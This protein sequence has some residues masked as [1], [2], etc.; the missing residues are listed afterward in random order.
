[1]SR[2]RLLPRLACF[3]LFLSAAALYADLPAITDED[4][5]PVESSWKG[6]MTQRG[7]HPDWGEIPSELDS[8]FTVTKRDGEDFEAELNESTQTLNITFVCKG[9]VL[10]KP[11]G[12]FELKF[13]S[14]EIK[15]AAPGTVGVVG[16]LYSAKIQGTS[17]KGTWKYPENNEGITLAGDFEWSME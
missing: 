16:V 13:E 5:F 15:K 6:K 11:G 7:T 12:G 4:P 9:K 14:M 17:V 3:F 1:M 10:R 2:I 8:V